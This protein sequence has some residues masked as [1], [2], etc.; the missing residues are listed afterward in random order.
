MKV[1]SVFLPSLPYIFL[2]FSFLSCTN[3]NKE[4][5]KSDSLD[6]YKSFVISAAEDA[7]LWA[8][9][10]SLQ[11]DTDT[12]EIVANLP[13]NNFDGKANK[14][15]AIFNTSFTAN[16]WARNKI[17]KEE[18]CKCQL[19]DPE[20]R[21]LILFFEHDTNSVEHFSVKPSNS[22]EQIQRVKAGVELGIF[23][24]EIFSNI[25]VKIIKKHK[26]I[27][28]ENG[29]ENCKLIYTLMRDK[30]YSLKVLAIR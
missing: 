27:S 13:K 12:L 28:I 19:I 7:A 3:S 21:A 18:V 14:S 25:P 15:E 26:V 11:G 22:S 5:Q 9:A 4:T 10:D 17:R 1:Q 6:A 23:Y 2:L 30:L 20:N 8:F 16:N 24:S 29:A